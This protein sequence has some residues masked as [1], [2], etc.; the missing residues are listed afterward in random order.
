MNNDKSRDELKRKR[1]KFKKIVSLKNIMMVIGTL[2]IVGFSVYSAFT[3]L[4]ATDSTMT[5][6]DFWKAVDAGEID[7]VRQI[8]SENYMIVEDTDGVTYRVV[9][10]QY[11]DFRKDMLEHGV[12]VEVSQSTFSKLLTSL[13]VTLPLQVAMYLFIVNF[14]FSS[15][16]SSG[17][18]FKVLKPDTIITFDDIAGM[19]ETKEEVKFAVAQLKNADRLAELGA[20]PCKGIILSGPPGTGK[21]MLARA[22]AG[23]SGVPL[24]SCSG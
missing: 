13:M 5:Y 23:E 19:S 7:N 8:D 9:D 16:I 21:T 20:K 3:Q 6:T 4:E 12:K 17:N 22:I 18:M 2:I 11:E 15:I 24:I 10:P 14:T 1:K